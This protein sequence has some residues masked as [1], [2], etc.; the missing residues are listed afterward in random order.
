MWVPFSASANV[1]SCAPRGR[2]LFRPRAPLH[3]LLLLVRARAGLVE[4][5]A[6]EGGPEVRKERVPLIRTRLEFDSL[7]I[8]ACS[9]VPGVG[10]VCLGRE[11]RLHP[12]DHRVKHAVLEPKA[13]ECA[14]DDLGDWHPRSLLK[15]DLCGR[16]GGKRQATRLD[17]ACT[18]VF[19]LY[20]SLV[21][22]VLEFLRDT[23]GQSDEVTLK[24]QPQGSHE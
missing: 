21:C 7:G 14:G 22:T 6:Q 15:R 24:L 8:L 19:T 2:G 16:A 5:V 3:P 18:V 4:E 20:R 11:A 13:R 12:V 17:E 10:S 1:Q 23:G 9:Y